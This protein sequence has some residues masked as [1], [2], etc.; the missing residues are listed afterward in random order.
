[1]SQVQ[2]VQSAQEILRSLGITGQ[3]VVRL[4][5]GEFTGGGFVGPLSA[6][7]LYSVG[8][9]GDKIEN[10]GAAT[11]DKR[12]EWGWYYFFDK[13]VADAF[14]KD[15]G[16]QYASSA[17]HLI[18][19]VTR[20]VIASE[21][22]INKLLG[23]TEETKGFGEIISGQTSVRTLGSKKYRHEWQLIGFP[24]LVHAAAVLFGF[25][26]PEFDVSELRNQDTTFT[27]ELFAKLCGNPDAKKGEED[28][29]T[30][31]VYYRQRADLWAALGESDPTKCHVIAEGTKHSTES[32]QLDACFQIALSNWL[33]PIYGRLRLVADPRVDALAGSGNRLN[34]G[35]VTDL[36]PNEAKAREAAASEQGDEGS[37]VSA[38]V[39]PLPTGYQELE[40]GRDI[41]EGEVER[42]KSM[43]PAV[44]AAQVGA[45]VS[46][47]IAW[48]EYKAL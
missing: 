2:Q 14:G 20:K 41:W 4:P 38:A 23:N 47:V 37:A 33:E 8:V 39:P 24:A 17:V 15:H 13:G 16:A 34:L 27:D 44:A 1:V 5:T 25:D 32:P 26:V 46:E 42:T 10:S 36:Y 35:I 3:T 29:Y 11:V 22:T 40:N 6:N 7:H 31:S 12:G 48:R 45:D 19:L 18:Q 30:N 9:E 43:A 21:D 28:Y